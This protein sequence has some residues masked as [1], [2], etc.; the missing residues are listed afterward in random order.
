MNCRSLIAVTACFILAAPAFAA[1]LDGLWQA[2]RRYGPD[3]RGTLLVTQSSDAWQAEIAGRKVP[4]EVSGDGLTFRIAEGK[5]GAFRGTFDKARTEIV[6][7]WISEQRVEN[8]LSFASPVIAD[9]VEPESMAWHCHPR[10][11][12]IHVLPEGRDEG[13]RYGLRVPPQ[14]RT[15]PRLVPVSGDRRSN[16]KGT[17]SGC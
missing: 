17:R 7:H 8:G 1:D 2:K 3:I 4:V 11:R 10:R 12:H 6:G 14:S 15:Q 9:A 5:E 13:R 16:G